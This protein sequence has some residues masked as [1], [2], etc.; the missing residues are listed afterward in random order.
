MCDLGM[1]EW[2]GDDSSWQVGNF[3]VGEWGDDKA[4]YAALMRL[5]HG[6]TPK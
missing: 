6:W 1:G 4:A 2:R 5:Y 3:G